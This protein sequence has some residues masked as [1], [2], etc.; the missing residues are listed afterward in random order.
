MADAP[1]VLEAVQD[2]R[3][4]LDH[5]ELL[6]D[7][8]SRCPMNQEEQLELVALALRQDCD[9]FKRTVASWEDRRL[10]RQGKSRTQHQRARRTAKVFDGDLEMVVLHAEFDQ[11]A[12]E[13]LRVALDAMSTKM[14]KHDSQTGGQRTF[15]QRNADAL[16]ALVTQEPGKSR[17]SARVASEGE[18]D[19]GCEGPGCGDWMH[20]APKP[21]KTTLILTAD[22]DA[23]TR[24]LKSASLID[25]TPVELDEIRRLACE[26]EIL[27]A[28]FNADSQPLYMGRARRAPTRAQRF[29]II[30]RDR[31]C[32]NCGLRPQACDFHHILPWEDGGPTDV[33]NLVLLCPKCHRKTHRHNSPRG[34][35][36]KVMIR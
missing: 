25:G 35:S 26:A 12:G 1:A 16:V 3:I 23:I 24:Q 31:A 2:R 11:I 4:T 20:T 18:E 33:P 17:N 28:I 8:H 32:T 19:C 15:E 14:L 10:A 27:P 29:A 21:Q 22:Y 5:A 30:R 9:N 13:R 6:A 7:S 36:R 34:Q